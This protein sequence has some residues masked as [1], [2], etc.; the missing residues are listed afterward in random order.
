MRPPGDRGVIQAGCN[1]GEEGALQC[2]HISLYW[3][4]D[5]NG[6]IPA[7]D[8]EHYR[9]TWHEDPEECHDY[10]VRPTVEFGTVRIYRR[11]AET[12]FSSDRL[13]MHIRHGSVEHAEVMFEAFTDDMSKMTLAAWPSAV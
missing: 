7:P 4:H 13:I 8:A 5:L 10:W 12:V 6:Y 1:T 11:G 3:S 2:F 9:P